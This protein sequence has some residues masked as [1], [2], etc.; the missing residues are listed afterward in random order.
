MAIV[1][2]ARSKVVSAL[3]VT[4]FGTFIT[5]MMGSSSGWFSDDST[6]P[7][8]L[9]QMPSDSASSNQFDSDNSN[10]MINGD[11][12]PLSS[13]HQH[14]RQKNHNNHHR[15]SHHKHGYH[16]KVLVMQYLNLEW[17]LNQPVNANGL[18]YE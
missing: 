17:Q 7:N 1:V 4:G 15:N 6:F 16:H 18:I 14:H 8:D 2:S 12:L 5:I 3:V 13:P 10:N 11:M 9:E